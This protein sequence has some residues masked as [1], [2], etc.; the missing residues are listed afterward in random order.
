ML[1]GAKVEGGMYNDNQKTINCRL[2]DT[3]TNMLGTKLCDRCWE[4][5]TRIQGDPELA[6]K[7]LEDYDA[8]CSENHEN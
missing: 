1:C 4:L 2:C 5:E 3:P 8:D 7:I 6:R